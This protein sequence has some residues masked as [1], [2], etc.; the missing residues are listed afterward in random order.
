M[1]K[2]AISDGPSEK[3]LH[4]SLMEDGRE[5]EVT[6]KVDGLGYYPVVIDQL[7]RTDNPAVWGWHGHVSG[8]I[9]FSPPVWGLFD[10]RQRDGVLIA[11]IPLSRLGVGGSVTKSTVEGRHRVELRIP[12]RPQFQ[13]VK[14]NAQGKSLEWLERRVGKGDEPWL[15]L[16]LVDRSESFIIQLTHIERFETRHYF[17]G[18]TKSISTS[19]SKQ[20][21]HVSGYW[22]VKRKNGFVALDVGLGFHLLDRL[23]A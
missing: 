6:F 1:I 7:A 17:E 20:P 19:E 18:T 5:Y 10:V 21:V 9:E 3:R 16:K 22:D 23:G 12:E 8:F 13:I 14:K 4:F 11:P 15:H 2:L